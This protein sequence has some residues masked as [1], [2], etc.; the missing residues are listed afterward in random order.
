[1]L[2]DAE[3]LMYDEIILMVIELSSSS[4]LL[5]KKFNLFYVLLYDGR[6]GD[7]VLHSF[8]LH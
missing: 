8:T 4:S 5:C 6:S 3:K 1:M 2:V 7:A